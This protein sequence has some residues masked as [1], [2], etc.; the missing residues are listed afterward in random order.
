M[1]DAASVLGFSVDAG[2]YPLEAVYAAANTFA[3]RAFVRIAKGKKGFLEVELALKPGVAGG[4]VLESEFYNELLHH[5]LRLKVSARHQ[6]LREKI[7]AQAL[8]SAHGPA[9]KAA[10]PAADKASDAALEK[11][12][13]K[14]LKEAESGS[15]KKDPLGIAVPWEKKRARN[16]G[17]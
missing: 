14:L 15:Y 3:G 11:E 6:A 17:K 13:E 4:A 5:A 2:I 12:I 16:T 7:V 1:K 9:G 8:L 10:A